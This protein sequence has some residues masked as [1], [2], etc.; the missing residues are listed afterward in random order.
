MASATRVYLEVGS[1]RTFA[2]AVDWPGWARSAASEGEALRALV[3]YGPRYAKALGR[4][5]LGFAPPKDVSSLNVVERVK[6]DATTDFGAPGVPPKLDMQTMKDADLERQIAILETI[7]KAFDRTVKAAKGKRLSKGP[8][9]GGRALSAIADHVVD[10]E[11]AYLSPMGSVRRGK[12]APSEPAAIRNAV[13]EVLWDRARGKP[14]P[15]NRRSKKPLWPAAYG[16][17]RVAWHALD[18]AWE[19]EDRS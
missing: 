19:I 17:R 9:G 5:K 15:P 13:I 6:G 16:V 7:W 11:R 1:K 3:D 2:C 4:K 12:E 18:H 10:A 14:P 8:R